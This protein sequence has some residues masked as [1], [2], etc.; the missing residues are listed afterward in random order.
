[1]CGYT[2]AC[3]LL[4][5]DILHEV[6]DSLVE[7]VDRGQ[8]EGGFVQGLGW[9]TCEELR[10]SDDGR[11]LTDAPSTYKIP[12]VGEVPQDMRVAL[13]RHAEPPGTDVI[14]GSKAVGEPP[15]MLA[16]S[17]REAIRDAVSAFGSVRVVPLASPCTPEA[18]FDA[19]QRVRA[20]AAVHV[21]HVAASRDMAPAK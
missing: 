4:R 8:I 5:V 11:L 14:Y 12:T 20:P 3:R 13:Y 18:I 2:G 7:A 17:V 16:L 15:L 10:W 19:I 9:L 21:A 1:V 6:G